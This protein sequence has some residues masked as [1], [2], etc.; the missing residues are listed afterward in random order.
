MANRL[1][2]YKLKAGASQSRTFVSHT[3]AESGIDLQVDPA[4]NKLNAC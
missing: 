3:H 4:M 1:R 2:S